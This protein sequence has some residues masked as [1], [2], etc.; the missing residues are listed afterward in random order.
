MKFLAKTVIAAALS[1]IAFAASAMT[2]IAD[3]ELSQVSGQ[4]GVSIAANLNVNI[5]SFVYGTANG[6][7]GGGNVAFNNISITGVVAATFGVCQPTCRV[8]SCCLL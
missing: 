3:S 4:D 7:E 6:A 1:S 2:P 8:T 5:G